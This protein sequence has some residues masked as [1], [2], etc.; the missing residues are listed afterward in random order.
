METVQYWRVARKWLISLISDPPELLKRQIY[1]RMTVNLIIVIP[2]VIQFDFF[3][4][5]AKKCK[6]II[7]FS[8]TQTEV[9]SKIRRFILWSEPCSFQYSRLMFYQ[10]VQCNVAE[11]KHMA[12]ESLA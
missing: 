1:W 2:I 7:H 4:V 11:S 8:T 12:L 3:A 10:D 6:C 5:F 9:L